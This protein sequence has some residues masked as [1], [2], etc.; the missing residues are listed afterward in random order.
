MDGAPS[1]A[2]GALAA[3]GAVLAERA[4]VCLARAVL[5]DTERDRIPGGT[6]HGVGI[7]VDAEVILGELAFARRGSLYFGVGLDV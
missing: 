4:E 2:F 6:L 5:A 1:L 3:R 7:Q